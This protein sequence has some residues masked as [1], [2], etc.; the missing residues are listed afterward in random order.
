MPALGNFAGGVLAEF[1]PVPRQVL[2]L[3]LHAAAGVIVAV[4]SIE[5]MPVGL[6]VEQVWVVILWLVAGAFC[7]SPECSG[8]TGATQR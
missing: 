1:V 6:Q 7:N 3:A 4:V 2:T 5:L 8:R